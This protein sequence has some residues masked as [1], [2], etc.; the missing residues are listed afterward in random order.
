MRKEISNSLYITLW[1]VI[2]LLVRISRLNDSIYE[3]FSFRQT[4]TAFGIRY[5]ANESLNPFTAQVPVLGPPW[6]IPFEFP[7]FQL[8][9]SLPTKYLSIE[10]AISGRITATLFFLLSSILLFLIL[11]QTNGKSVARI[12][13][14]IF[15]L[16]SFSLEWGSA[17]L[18][19]W[20]SVALTLWGIY[21]LILHKKTNSSFSI[22]LMFALVVLVFASLTKVTTT[23]PWIT[24]FVIFFVAK[25]LMFKFRKNVIIITV[26]TSSFLPFILWNSFADTVKSENPFTEWLVSDSMNTWNFGSLGQ[27]LQPTNYF[28]IFE[29]IDNLIFGSSIYLIII[30]TLVVFI[31][32]TNIIFFNFYLFTG[33]F[34]VAIFFNLYV[35][36]DYYLIAIYPA[37]IAMISIILSS[38]IESLVGTR[39]YRV[40][41][42]LPVIFVVILTYIS[43]LGKSYLIEYRTDGGIP[44][45]SQYIMSETEKNSKIIMLGCDWDP[46]ILFFAERKGL[47]LTPGRFR[48]EDLTKSLIKEYQYVY[49]CGQQEL[50]I[51]T[52]DVKL[53]DQGNNL[54]KIVN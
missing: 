53:F 23:V 27:R 14:P 31:Q 45:A 18:I 52:A 41:S 33:I 48:A 28:T 1:V 15:L 39:K 46:T 25:S 43:P 10:E 19:D 34:A 5:F 13:M 6:K 44:I 40:V 47:M 50:Q 32:K 16:T 22:N 54:F 21:L 26:L 49:T 38:G 37:I 24:A 12:S 3:R 30:I 35:K 42:K 20:L 9:A 51:L 4:Q 29:K 36:H 11:Q 2:G 7:I 17:V 8:I